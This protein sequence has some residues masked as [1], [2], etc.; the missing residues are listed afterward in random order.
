MKT[1]TIIIIY[2]VGFIVTALILNP[3]KKASLDRLGVQILFSVLWPIALNVAAVCTFLV[4]VSIGINNFSDW[5]S[6][7]IKKL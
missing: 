4:I 2:V 7:L 6:K 5:L 3:G 1:L